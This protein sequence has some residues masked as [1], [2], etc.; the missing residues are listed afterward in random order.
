[1]IPKCVF[2]IMLAFS[3]GNKKFHT[4]RIIKSKIGARRRDIFQCCNF[5][6]E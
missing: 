3:H 6:T 2:C 1:M 4:R 5:T